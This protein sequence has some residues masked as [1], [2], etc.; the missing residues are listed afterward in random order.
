MNN[1]I[2]I[3]KGRL[4]GLYGKLIFRIWQLESQIKGIKKGCSMPYSYLY[5]KLC[6]NFSIQKNEVRELL[7]LLRDVGF[8]E[9][10]Q[11]GIK[12]RFKING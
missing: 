10:N 2:A 5:E 12:L 3:N 6:R 7:F 1:Q 9:I 11:K 8:L 4:C